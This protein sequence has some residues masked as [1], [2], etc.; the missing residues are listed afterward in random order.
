MSTKSRKTGD[1]RGKPKPSS[2]SQRP[3]GEVPEDLSDILGLEGA[4]GSAIPL[5]EQ[6]D[7]DFQSLLD[8]AQT[9][10]AFASVVRH[11]G[12]NE[13][14][15]K[16]AAAKRRQQIRAER[17]ENLK[18]EKAERLARLER[19]LKQ[20][21]EEEN[22]RV[23]IP[24][25]ES[26]VQAG[27]PSEHQPRDYYSD[28]G[29]TEDEEGER[30]PLIKSAFGDAHD[31][32]AHAMQQGN[33]EHVQLLS[34][35]RFR[36]NA[37]S[38]SSESDAE[39]HSTDE[40]NPVKVDMDGNRDSAAEVGSPTSRRVRKTQMYSMAATGGEQD[41]EM[42]GLASKSP[43]P[44]KKSMA[45]SKSTYIRLGQPDGVNDDD[46]CCEKLCDGESGCFVNTIC[47]PFVMPY[48]GCRIYCCP[49]LGSMLC[50]CWMWC[51]C[52]SRCCKFEDKDFPAGPE[53]LGVGIQGDGGRKTAVFSDKNVQWIRASYLAKSDSLNADGSRGLR[54]FGKRLD[55]STVCQGRLGDC[56]LLSAMA[57][58]AD[59]RGAIQ[60]VFETHSMDVRG[61]YWVTLY[62]ASFSKNK[63][64]EPV[65]S[66]VSFA[67]DDKI[68]CVEDSPGSGNW[69]PMFTGLRNG[70][71]WPLLLE[72]AFAKMCGSYRALEG[73]NALWALQAMTGDKPYMFKHVPVSPVPSG[74]VLKAGEELGATW[75]GSQLLSRFVENDADKKTAGHFIDL[76]PSQPGHSLDSE[77]MWNVLLNFH[78]RGSVL[79]ASGVRQD[80]YAG[81]RAAHAY[82]VLDFLEFEKRGGVLPTR[83]TATYR[84]TTTSNVQRLILIRNPWGQ[85]EWTGDWGLDSNLWGT[86]DAVVAKNA[87][88]KVKTKRG[89]TNGCFWMSWEDFNRSWSKLH[90]LQ[91]SVDINNLYLEYDE[92]VCCGEICGC[93]KGCCSFFFLCRGIDRLYF[94]EKSDDVDT[95][96]RAK[97]KENGCERCCTRRCCAKFL[98]WVLWYLMVPVGI[99]LAIYF[100]VFAGGSKK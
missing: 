54:L 25:R 16:L 32:V 58:L 64:G 12:G 93:V 53:S 4:Q 51:C 63:H 90:V 13:E 61:K 29:S 28:G 56:W 70:E 37:Q 84:S 86:V 69:R 95:L 62:D 42:R 89:A 38:S 30:G 35:V 46:G 78:N 40:D 15:S 10:D 9:S 96:E 41:Y 60:H 65:G 6:D 98:C 76:D 94:S 22:R 39:R 7:G 44:S 79:S 67:I 2:R 99:G 59:H 11:D 85:G 47:C 23:S 50:H 57:C 43:V 3:E 74:S 91:R 75:K 17:E 36:A 82:S 72:K 31:P 19:E 77:E 5:D 48:Q 92:G 20:R 18:R 52:S 88:A 66:W 24:V 87:L 34:S 1:E 83:T 81:L 80:G 45:A 73:G 14:D 33:Q 100:L 97:K 21:E 27:R 55:A 68:P 8:T 26:A 71:L 49:T